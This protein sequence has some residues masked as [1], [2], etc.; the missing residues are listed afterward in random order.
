MTASAVAL[1]ACSSSKKTTG[2]GL[3]GGSSATTTNQTYKIG[4]IAA[5]SGPNAQLGINERNGAKLAVDQAN[6]SGKYKFKV[7][8]DPVDSE[9]DPAKAPAAATQLISDPTVIAVI[10]PA[11]SG[12]SKAVD[13]NFCGASPSIPIVTASASNAKLSTLG[14]TCW[15]RII[16]NDNVEGSQGADW[17]AR[18]KAKKVYVLNDLSTYGQGVA[19]TMADELKAKGVSVVTNGVDGVTTKNYGPIA[20]TI[21]ASGADAL[22]YGGYDTAAAA[23]AKALVGAGFH[24]RTVTGNGGKSSTFTTGSGTAGDGWYFTC[25]CQDATV[26]PSAK[27]FAT[28]YQTAFSTPPSTYSPEAYD[29]ANLLID[30]ISK[31]SASATATRTSVMTALNAEDFKGITTDIKFQPNG[32]VVA[33]NLI[34]NLFQQKNGAIVGLGDINQQN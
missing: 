17:L 19:T 22:F 5:L 3:G 34:V 25:G 1:S 6:S 24:G 15:H 10:G 28:A 31:A 21:A 16:P 13:G 8:L 20:Q 14:F 18:T 4:F 29:A 9:G 2:T 27:A 30:S 26:A 33:S 7:T 32:E 23:L 11:F 12:E